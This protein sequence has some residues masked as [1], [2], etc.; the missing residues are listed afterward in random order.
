M[1]VLIGFA[2]YFVPLQIGYRDMAFPR[3]NAMSVW[4]FLFS[5]ML[6]YFAL[7]EGTLPG[8]LVRVRATDRP[9][10]TMAAGATFWA[11]GLVVAGAGSIATA[12]NLIVTIVAHRCPGMTLRKMPLLCGWYW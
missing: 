10:L 7:I 11:V 8:W 2:N 12:L 5:G 6:M 9:P 4:L 1:P 3:L